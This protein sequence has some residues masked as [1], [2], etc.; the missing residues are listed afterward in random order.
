MLPDTTRDNVL[1]ILSSGAEMGARE[2][3]KQGQLSRSVYKDIRRLLKHGW[4]EAVRIEKTTR[5][6][7]VIYKITPGAKMLIH[8]RE[9]GGKGEGLPKD[10]S[11]HRPRRE[12]Q[13]RRDVRGPGSSARGARGQGVPCCPGSVNPPWDDGRGP[14]PGADG[15]ASGRGPNRT[16]ERGNTLS[17]SIQFLRKEL[18]EHHRRILELLGQIEELAT[19]QIPHTAQ[20]TQTP[21]GGL[22][23]LTDFCRS[24][25]WP[26]LRT[27]RRWTASGEVPPAGFTES[28][29]VRRVGGAVLID[30]GAFDAWVRAQ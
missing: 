10:S 6:P 16:D 11:R 19:R 2:I 30:T 20:Q 29:A 1:K 8:V 25:T 21:T 17:T 27:M 12:G 9:Q 14:I 18:E 24:R 4:I 7:R 22:M 28:G 5:K 13:A 23:R 26:S 3:M 15:R